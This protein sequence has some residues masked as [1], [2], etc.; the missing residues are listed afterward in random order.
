MQFTMCSDNVLQTP[1]ML[2]VTEEALHEVSVLL[3]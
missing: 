2:S 1:N 3:H